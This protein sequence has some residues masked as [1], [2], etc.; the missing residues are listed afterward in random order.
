MMKRAAHAERHKSSRTGWLR[1]GVLGANDGIISVSSL[2]VGVASSATHADSVLLSGIA[3]LVAGA[4]SMAAGEYVSVSSQADAEAADLTVERRELRDDPEGERRELASLYVARGLTAELADAVAGQLT[5]H[6]AL[7]A[8]AHD[9]LGITDTNRPRPIQAAFASAAA[10]TSGAIAPVIVAAA[11]PP[12]LVA[13]GISVTALVLLIALGVVGAVAGG[14][15][16]RT[17]VIRITFWGI[18]ALGV[19]AAI[20]HLVGT[21]V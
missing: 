18:V 16:W 5:A 1:A 9:E 7:S 6:D 20:G 3:A 14:A 10:F 4:M 8:H 2:M 21:A 12:A 15:D 11:L 19:T 13:I 17:S